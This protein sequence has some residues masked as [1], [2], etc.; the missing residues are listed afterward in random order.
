MNNANHNNT[1]FPANDAKAANASQLLPEIETAVRDF[2]K[3]HGNDVASVKRL[4]RDVR[5]AAQEGQR[6]VASREHES[7]LRQRDEAVTRRDDSRKQIR[8][9]EPKVPTGHRRPMGL[10]ATFLLLLL[11]GGLLTVLWIENGATAQTL[12]ST[13]AF[14]VDTLLKGR[15]IMFTPIAVGIAFI[16]GFKVLPPYVRTPAFMAAFATLVVAFLTWAVSFAIQAQRYQEDASQAISLADDD[17]EEPSTGQDDAM[18]AGEGWSGWLM[19]GSLVIMMPLT[20]FIGHTGVDY[21]VR[22]YQDLVDNEDHL[23]AKEDVKIQEATI[24]RL[25]PLIAQAAGKVAALDHEVEREVTLALSLYMALRSTASAALVVMALLLTGCADLTGGGVSPTTQLDRWAA[26]SDKPETAVTRVLAISPRLPVTEKAQVREQLEAEIDW[27]ANK[28]PLGSVTVV[29]DALDSTPVARLEAVRGAARIRKKALAKPARALREFLNQPPSRTELDGRIH[30]P[31]LA[32]TAKQWRLPTGSHVVVLGSPLFLN[33]DKDKFFSMADGRVPSDGCLFEDPKLNLYSVVGREK[34]LAGQFWHLGWSD[35]AVFEDDTHRQAV[36]RFWFLYL[37]AQSAT[38]VTAQPSFVAATDAA[39][40]RATD[41]LMTADPDSSAEAAMV[42]IIK[43]Q[44]QKQVDIVPRRLDDIDPEVD[45]SRTSHQSD[46]EESDSVPPQDQTAA[47][48][49]GEDSH[50]EVLG[51]D[52]R[53]PEIARDQHGNVQGSDN[54][55]IT[56]GQMQGQ[57]IVLATFYDDE[58]VDSSPLMNALTTKGFTVERLR[59]PLPPLNEFDSL[60]DES[61]QLWLWSSPQSGRL[62]PSHLRTI[63]DRWESGTLALC[64]LADNTPFTTEASEVLSTL[65]PGCTIR[66]D[67][68][69]RGML[70]ALP[71]DDADDAG[72][73]ATSPLFHNITTLYEGTT[74]STV[75]GP[76]LVPVCCA[77]DGSP[78]IATLQ[79]EGSSRL[80]IHGGFTSFFER[81]WD[82]AGVSRFAVNCAGWLSGAD[83][84]VHTRS[85]Q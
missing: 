31:R 15:L 33:D 71:K 40:E 52:S 50:N 82:D 73:D 23:S 34:A 14:G 7:L 6:V 68:P 72:F 63:V 3:G 51:T 79:Q 13:G 8:N 9:T 57:R 48:Q 21:I 58:E 29:V 41:P 59:Y 5:R 30:F 65:S 18:H 37:Q 67:Y 22:S 56:D 12:L 16:L 80:V 78:L 2:A 62:P 47:A 43:V 55:L 20:T 26:Q 36:L 4:A 27:I 69:G 25:D 74:I 46:H 81:F 54:D 19:F 64:L 32:Q 17:W 24:A 83:P 35:D 76:G 53:I 70:H 84:K 45:A 75:S 42:R 39:R 1:R 77:S 60:L 44:R 11:I 28:A 66:G 49:R 10:I 85:R 38:L 61:Q